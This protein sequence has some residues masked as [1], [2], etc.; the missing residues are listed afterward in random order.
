MIIYLL[1]W[2]YTGSDVPNLRFPKYS[3]TIKIW[4]CSDF[5]KFFSTNSL[6]WDQLSYI[7]KS[8]IVNL[9]YGLIHNG[10][11]TLINCDKYH[12]PFIQSR[13]KNFTLCKNGDVIFA[14]ASEDTNDI[15]KPVELVN[16]SN[17]KVVAG[18]H[19]IHARDI[20]NLTTLGFKGYLFSSYNFHKQ[21][22]RLTQG[23]KIFSININNFNNLY[24]GIPSIEEQND[25][26]SLLSKI[27]ERI[28]TQNKIIKNLMLQINYIKYK[29][30]KNYITEY[31]NSIKHKFDE[32][33]IAYKK[34]NTSN[35]QQYT[36]GKNG[37]KIISNIPIYS[38]NSHI[39]F[40]PNSLILGLGIEEIGI[41]INTTGCC[42]PIYKTYKINNSIV[43]TLFLSIF[44]N[45]YFFMLKNYVTKKSTRRNFEFD[46]KSLT[47]ITFT[48]PKI[49][50]QKKDAL[51]IEKFYIKL[52]KEKDILSLYK[53]QKA[54]LL[55]NMFI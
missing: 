23:T 48:L 46:Y 34:L 54:Y 40:E 49:E 41:S 30:F 27:D 52:Q 6:S 33:F 13:I 32:M 1:Y 29:L 53:K 24:V 22:Y 11:P 45:K 21:V 4:K 3:N 8:N 35:L 44:V 55:Q 42:S 38:T 26:V 18:L 12:L 10:A 7:N 28:R 9:H 14:D 5:L 15:C 47:N 37:I 31:S 39:V 51:M 17:S 43:N 25:I 20:K 19:T 2:G 36:I 16:T 50:I